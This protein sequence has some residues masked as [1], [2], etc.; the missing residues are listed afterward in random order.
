MSVHQY[1]ITIVLKPDHHEWLQILQ[2]RNVLANDIV[3]VDHSVDGKDYRMAIIFNAI[4]T[5]TRHDCHLWRKH[6][7]PKLRKLWL[8]MIQGSDPTDDIWLWMDGDEQWL[9]EKFGQWLIE[10][11][12]TGPDHEADWFDAHW[13]LRHRIDRLHNNASHSAEQIRNATREQRLAAICWL[14][15]NS[16]RVKALAIE[17]GCTPMGMFGPGEIVES[18]RLE[19]R[20]IRELWGAFPQ[21]NTAVWEDAMKKLEEA[22]CTCL[23]ETWTD[24]CLQPWFNML[25]WLE[26]RPP[27]LEV[28]RAYD[29]TRCQFWYASHFSSHLLLM[30]ILKGKVT[31]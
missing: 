24:E 28:I 12:F 18:C 5:A 23:E 21:E 31:L 25:T 17:L 15:W 11:S 6:L 13:A 8:E 9:R 29:C 4:R 10:C 30:N 19:I 16:G 20:T 2:S 1:C 26:E 27:T 7:C 14:T 3:R 22:G